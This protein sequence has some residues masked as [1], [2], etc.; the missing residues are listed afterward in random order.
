MAARRIEPE[1]CRSKLPSPPGPSPRGRG[2]S[3]Y[4]V[5][6]LAHRER[7]AE[8][9][10][11]GKR[12]GV[13]LFRNRS[14]RPCPIQP[15]TLGI[16]I[17][18]FLCLFLLHATQ[19]LS[20]APSPQEQQCL[21]S[22]LPLIEKGQLPEAEGKLLEGLKLYPHSAILSNALGIVYERQDRA[23]AAA[24]A[25]RNALK[26][27]PNFTAAQL[28]LAL[29][30]QRQGKNAEATA[31]FN[32][33]GSTTSNVEA[34]SA[35]GLG[36]AQCEDYA[37]A[38]RVLEKARSLQPDSLPVAYNLS[39]AYFKN[40][41]FRPAQQVL[42][43]LPE[44]A[45]S[46][47]ADLVFLRG[48]IGLAL[49]EPG[50]V[51]DM[52]WACRL[53]PTKENFCTEAGLGFIREERLNEAEAVLQAGLEKSTA[54]L[55]ILSTL[56]LVE[57]RLGKYAA[58]KRTYQQVL[59]KDAGADDAR[60]GLVFLLYMSGDLNEAR[61][62]AE[63]GLKNPGSDFYL[64]ELHAMILFR[65]SPQ[66]WAEALTSINRALKKNPQFAPAYFLRGKI[67][68]EQGEMEAALKDFQRAA[69]LDPKYPL[70]HYKIAQVLLRF[71][72]TA[73]A[74]SARKRFFELGQIR[75][76]ELLVRQT[77]DVLMRKTSQ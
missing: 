9:R 36:L 42:K 2:E 67:A 17:F 18:L 62:V 77:Q 14:Y 44:K 48:R 46:Q 61:R 41:D 38:I 10:V 52:A 68:L 35:A 15:E 30:Y 11:R 16:G 76:E 40:G 26:A 73:E 29:L 72:K 4:L 59:D 25:Y 60:E 49:S 8:G 74:E 24:V 19:C 22:V 45:G 54:S 37:G 27:L 50:A 6:S 65:L 47:D 57:F 12:R 5:Y 33:V 66:T 20:Q 71:G 70:P 51:D 56:G 58:A 21:F 3:K 7:V 55:S 69:Q 23:D 1:F 31:L 64:S 63:E 28:H 13:T 53:S 32:Q 43:A 34:L 75:E 39:L